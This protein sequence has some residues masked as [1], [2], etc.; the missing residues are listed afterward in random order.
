MTWRVVEDPTTLR[1]LLDLL[2]EDDPEDADGDPAELR[3]GR[4]PVRKATA[5]ADANRKRGADG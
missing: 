4:R 1:H 5:A 2:F 3:Q